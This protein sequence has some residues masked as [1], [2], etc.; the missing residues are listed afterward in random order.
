VLSGKGF[1]R[2]EMTPLLLVCLSAT[3]PLVGMGLLNL[4]ARLDRS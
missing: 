4:Q 3:M 1:G 2:F